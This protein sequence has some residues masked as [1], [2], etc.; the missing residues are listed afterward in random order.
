VINGKNVN[1]HI[2]NHHNICIYLWKECG[3]I[4][5]S[6]YFQED[7]WFQLSGLVVPAG[8]LGT[9][10]HVGQHCVVVVYQCTAV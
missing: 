3:K 4:C 9:Q 5:P 1:F 6:E 2:E 7:T 10:N 8:Y